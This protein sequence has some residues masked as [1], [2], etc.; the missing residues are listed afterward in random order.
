[1]DYEKYNGCLTLPS[2]FV[3]ERDFKAEETIELDW[4]LKLPKHFSLGERIYSTNYQNG[5]GSCTS[6]ATSHGVQIL[7]VKA[8]WVKPISSNLITPNRKDLRTKMGHNLKDF[9]DSWDYVEKAVSTALKMWISNEEW[10]ES[11]FDGYCVEDWSTTD[12]WIERIKRYLY[13]WNPVVWCLRGNANTRKEL[14]SGQLKTY[15]EVA[16]RTGWHA[17]C[18]VGWDEWGLWFVNSRRTNDGKGLKSRFYV[19]YD[20]L[21]D[22]GSMF[23]RRYWLP[24]KKEQAK[25]DPEYIKR[26]N[27]YIAILKLLKKTYPIESSNMQQAIEAFSK[28]CRKEYPEINEELPINS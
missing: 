13:N 7:N 14:T 16:N 9:N 21:K 3:D 22:A 11:T 24:F 17:I 15:V 4:S 8:K 12:K 10:G 2:E 6:N 28:V 26:K 25:D 27:G 19:T 18:C 23:N 1:M 20:F 5:W